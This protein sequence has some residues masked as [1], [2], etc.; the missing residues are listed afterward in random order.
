M[1][2]ARIGQRST[3]S[4]FILSLVACAS[5][6]TA[7]SQEPPK[8]RP[9]PARTLIL[10]QKTVAS[11]SATLAVLDSAGRLLPN[12]AVELPNDVK[13]TTDITGRAFFIAPLDPGPFTAKIAGQEITASSTVVLRTAPAAKMS[14]VGGPKEDPTGG[15]RVT[16][17][18]HIL[19]MHDRFSLEGVGFQGTA[20]S[21]QVFLADQ[22][23]LVVASS[24]VSLVILPSPR[25]PIGAIPLRV[26]SGGKDT[27]EIPVTAVLLEFTGPSEPPDAGTAA[28]ITLHVHGTSDPV[29]VE[30][31]NGSPKIIQFPGGNVQRLFTSGGA[32]NVAPVE[33]KFLAPGDYE[34]TA[35]LIF[36]AGGAAQSKI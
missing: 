11:G 19:D 18:P 4:G 32:Q 20:D 29:G 30:V 8:V 13:V 25:I 27:E 36:S 33:V 10:P 14:D 23:C 24:P 34:L 35:R 15:L 9:T 12:V 26:S 17:Y 22:Q 31:R 21:N 6:I 16:A 3:L 28:E 2:R 7:G 5:V 1:S